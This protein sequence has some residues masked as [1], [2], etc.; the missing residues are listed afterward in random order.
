MLSKEVHQWQSGDGHSGKTHINLLQT[1]RSTASEWGANRAG[2]DENPKA[3]AVFALYAP[4]P[5]LPKGARK[6]PVSQQEPIR[7]H[8]PELRSERT[9]ARE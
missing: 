5:F 8:L 7:R 2:A 1:W 3:D 9:K 6:N 4:L